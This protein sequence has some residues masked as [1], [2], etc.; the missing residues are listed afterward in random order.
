[1]TAFIG[2]RLKGDLTGAGGP[3]QLAFLDVLL[4]LVHLVRVLSHAERLAAVRTLLDRLKFKQDWFLTV[5]L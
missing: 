3:L 4:D 2:R 5:F 1:M